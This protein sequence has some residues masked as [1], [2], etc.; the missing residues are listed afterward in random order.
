VV[1]VASNTVV[2]PEWRGALIEVPRG[3]KGDP[4]RLAFTTIALSVRRFVA[5]SA[6]LLI[7]LTRNDRSIDRVADA[8]GATRLARIQMHGIDTDVIC[9]ERPNATPNGPVVDHLWRRRHQG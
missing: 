2:H 1:S 6:D 5:S 4:A 9:I 7:A 3:Q 8:L